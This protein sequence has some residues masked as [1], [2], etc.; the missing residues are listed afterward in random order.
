MY[1]M[2]YDF[3]FIK[4]VNKIMMKTFCT[5]NFF[6]TNSFEEPL[7]PLLLRKTTMILVMVNNKKIQH[8]LSFKPTYLLFCFFFSRQIHLDITSCLIHWLYGE[9]DCESHTIV[10]NFPPSPFMREEWWDS[11]LS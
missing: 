8:K 7:P 2:L 1:S 3:I 10:Q 5:V 6:S 4:K 11:T 9:N